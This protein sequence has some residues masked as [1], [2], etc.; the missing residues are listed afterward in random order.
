MQSG[1][2]AGTSPVPAPN[3]SGAKVGPDDTYFTS[4]AQRLAP[5]SAS[6]LA[7]LLVSAI[8]H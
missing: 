2:L 5:W 6:V 3:K 8:V 1:P 4:A 7:M